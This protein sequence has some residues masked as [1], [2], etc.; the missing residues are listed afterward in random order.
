MGTQAPSVNIPKIATVNDDK[1][2]DFVQRCLV[3]ILQPFNGMNDRSIVVMDNASIHHVNRV[4]ATI[5]ET[6]ALVRFLS[7]YS[8]DL[9]PIEE[10]FTKVKSYLKAAYDVTSSPNLMITMVFYSVF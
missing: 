6:G 1:F 2:C 10:V 8:P 9:N 7:P 3:P 4:V 5:Q